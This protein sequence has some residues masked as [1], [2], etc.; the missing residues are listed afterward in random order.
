[1][2]LQ[3]KFGTYALILRSSSQ[4]TITVGKLGKIK[5]RKGY[6]IY[7]GSA[8]GPGGVRARV[9]RHCHIRKPPHWHIDYIRPVKGA[10][11]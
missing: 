11:S 7:V 5:M 2:T 8:F 6:Y 10:I 4:Q 9:K 1:M 3:Q